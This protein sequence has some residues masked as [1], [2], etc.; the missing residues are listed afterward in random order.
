[1]K[2]HLETGAGLHIVRGY[3]PGRV[4]VNQTIYRASVVVLPDRILADWP[5]QRFDELRAEH[6]ALIAALEPEIVVL[7]TGVRLQ[8]PAA[9]ILAPLAGIG[10]EVMDTAAACRTYNILMGEGRRVAA[11]L[12]MIE[13]P[14]S[15]DGP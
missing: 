1:M 6:F 11:A 14:L 5:P 10:R 13:S 3:A 8:W 7:G 9:A 15:T 4:T 2:L 12:L